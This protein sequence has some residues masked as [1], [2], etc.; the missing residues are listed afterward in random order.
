[1]FIHIR[2]KTAVSLVCALLLAALTAFVL[3]AALRGAADDA[4]QNGKTEPPATEADEPADPTEA[5]VDL[6][7]LMYHSVCRNNKV[8]SEYYITPE[9]FES[10]L[11]YLKD[12]GYT[13]VFIS[14]IA[15]YAESKGDLPEKPV[16]LTFDDGYYNWLTVVLPLLE[17][18]DM[19]ATFNVVGEYTENEAQAEARSPAYSY[20]TWEEIAAL[21]D[22]GRA[23]IGSHTWGMHTLGARRGCK[24]MAGES[25]A[26]YETALTGDLSRLNDA[27]Q[28]NCGFAPATFAYP[29]GEISR[30]S[31]PVLRS[32]GFRAALTCDERVNKIVRDPGVLFSLGRVNRAAHYSTAAFMQKYNL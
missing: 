29:Y 21:R 10:D 6:P 32:L 18:Y 20:L 24:K 11:Q 27:L 22:S 19:K 23:E 2:L 15:D 28:T 13:A 12:H 8:D 26:H 31:V 17:R 16:A 7:I 14:E 1:M 30:E 4:P 9:K 25:A 5:P 3:P